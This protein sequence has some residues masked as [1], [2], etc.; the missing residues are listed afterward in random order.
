MSSG[1]KVILVHRIDRERAGLRTAFEALPNVQVTGERPDL[2]S[3][4]ALA[5]QSRP[6]ILVLELT[7]PVD[8]TLTAAAQYKLDNPDVTIFLASE[9]FDSE[10]LMRAMR[11]GASEILRRPLDRAALSQAV[12][13]VTALNSR[14]SGG[15]GTARSV[16][17]VF[18]NKGGQGVSTI[19]TNLA[20][21]IRADTGR[22]VV[23]A[24]FDYHSGDVAFML[25]VNP[26]RSLG[27]LLVASM[28]DSATVQDT[29]LKHSSGVYVLSQPEQL[30]RVEGVTGK[31]VGS[32]LEIMSST[33]DFVV[34]DAPHVFNDVTLEIFDRT[35]SILLVAEPSVPS[36]R[37]ARRSLEIFQKLNYLT[38]P[39]RVRLIVNR[40]SDQSAITNAQLEDTLGMTV[41]GG[42][43]NDY[44]IVSQAINMG[45]PLCAGSPQGR[46]GR[47]IAALARQLVPGAE[48]R[49]GNA[50][51]TATPRRSGRLRLFGKG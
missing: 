51:E 39:D 12:E 41:F 10:T 28:I 2:R 25:G 44:T 19:A 27:D 6:D 34:V 50:V 29:L 38:L 46:A 8:E 42:I 24:D 17:T 14:K 21:S 32:V 23:L 4:M 3:G 18:S 13:R 35:S 36:V 49:N 5:H 45:Q 26:V 40:R 31:Q 7:A 43:T 15:A 37:A 33:F 16:F 47:D 30:D 11:A 20:L 22:E 9:V 48:S 1:L